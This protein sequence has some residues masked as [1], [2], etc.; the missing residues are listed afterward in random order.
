MAEQLTLTAT[1][2]SKHVQFSVTYADGTQLSIDMHPHHA[3]ALSDMLRKAAH[4]TALKLQ[5]S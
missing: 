4:K 2:K 3:L 5:M 1:P